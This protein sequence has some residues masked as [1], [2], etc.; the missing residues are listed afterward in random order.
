MG[1]VKYLLHWGRE[2]VHYPGD[3]PLSTVPCGGGGDHAHRGVRLFLGVPRLPRPGEAAAGRLLCILLLRLR[4]LP[5]KATC[6]R[7]A[8]SCGRTETSWPFIWSAPCPERVR[9]HTLNSA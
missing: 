3:D 2:S 6:L 9:A 7:K 1:A 5:P 4:L 8:L